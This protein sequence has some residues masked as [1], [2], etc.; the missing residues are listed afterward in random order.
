MG[1]LFCI[2]IT[3]L[4]SLMSKINVVN[5]PWITFEIPSKHP[6]TVTHTAINNSPPN[7]STEHFM[8]TREL[9]RRYWHDPHSLQGFWRLMA[10]VLLGSPINAGTC[11]IF[12]KPVTQVLILHG[13]RQIIRSLVIKH[14]LMLCIMFPFWFS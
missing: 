10:A 5:G 9:I 1:F 8:I 12:E 7:N 3:V 11:L 14:R 2:W 4:L 6:S 13:C